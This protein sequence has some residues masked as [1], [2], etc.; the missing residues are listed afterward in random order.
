MAPRGV[1]CATFCTLV[2]VLGN[3]RAQDPGTSRWQA[4][5]GALGYYTDNFYY[6]GTDDARTSSLGGLVNPRA[7]Y[8]SSRG[9]VDLGVNAE[10]E[11]GTFDVPGSVD[12]YADG[13]LNGSVSWLTSRRSRW[14]FRTAFR[15][16]HD[17]FGTNRTEDAT[18]QDID[19]DIWH[20]AE[21]GVKFRYGAPE[22][23]IN[24]EVGL[25][26]LDRS[27]Q[28]NEEF[29][30]FLDYES[31]SVQYALFF[32]FT[33]KTSWV[34]DFTRVN[35]LFDE[36]AGPVDLRSGDEYRLRTGLRW[37]ATAKT[38]GD[39]RVGTFRRN[40]EGDDVSD[41]GLDWQATVQWAPRARTVLRL[42][43]GRNTQESYRADTRVNIAEN[44][45]L[46]WRQNW[47]SRT[48]TEARLDR[49]TTE[50]RG[51]GRE[52]TLYNAA[53]SLDYM[54]SRRMSLVLGVN[55]F[56]RESNEA[57]SEFERL[58]TSLG[59]RVGY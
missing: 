39:I 14:D 5:V 16:G 24:A 11:I 25:S 35:V 54:L 10:A 23:R 13:L 22:A 32:N 4:D 29:T 53:L 40:Y 21:A 34:F 43:S 18:A 57:T 1:G 33:P 31:T 58:T 17:P 30:Q 15:R 48:N 7:S 47:S 49:T 52:D 56:K 19:L 45:T 51:A 42:G 38:S 59:V 6:D 9:A 36:P 37:L 41:Q 20:A 28:T 26:A 50:F 55:T 12:D 3:A 8:K 2:F 46:T 44:V 27:Y